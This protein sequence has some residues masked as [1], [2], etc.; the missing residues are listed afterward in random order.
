MFTE[1]QADPTLSKE[2]FETQ[3]A[4][5]RAALLKA[6]YNMLERADRALLIVVAGIDGAGK[7]AAINLLNEWMDPRHIHTLGFGA[8]EA[9]ELERPPLWRYWNEMPAKGKTGIV[10]GSWYVPLLREAVR[11][12]PRQRRI[13]AH[14]EAIRRFEAMLAADGVQVVKLWYHLSAKAQAARTKRLLASPETAWQVTRDDRRVQKKFDRVCDAGRLA[15]DLTHGAH[16]PW[17][18]IPSADEALRAVRTS[19]TVLAALRQRSIPRVPPEF[20]EP[21]TR[22]PR[23]V[24]RLDD[25][26]YESHLDK[27]EYEAELGLLQGRLARAVRSDAFR[28]RTLVLVFEGQDAAGKGGTI[29]RVTRALDARQFDI[30]PIGAPQPHELAR[31]YLWRFWRRLPR[32]G[33]IAIFDRS[34][35]GRVLVERVERLA[36]PTAWRRAYGEINDF[37][38]QLADHGAVVLKFWLAVTADEQLRRFRERERSPFKHFKITA[39]DWRNRKQWNAYAAAV[40]DMLARTD[41]QRAPWHVV[42]SNDKRYARIQVLRHIV[43]ALED[44]L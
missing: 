39:E 7:G 36:A 42:P 14:A 3:E 13:E 18:I 12:K 21:A 32:Q 30:S 34:W 38:R 24:R 17:T 28:K 10:F 16:A 37:E 43:A 15:I 35:Y 40:N 11:K 1:A 27:T 23:Q 25:V 26:D 20:V 9:D 4:R 29:R 41:T 6:Q 33:R 19:E 22:P 44:A 31:P 8:P 5:L 2:E